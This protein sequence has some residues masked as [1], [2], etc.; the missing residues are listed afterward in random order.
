MPTPESAKA[1]ERLVE[2]RNQLMDAT[3]R[4]N[5]AGR[6]STDRSREVQAEWDV[7]FRAFEAAANDFT[8]SVEQLRDKLDANSGS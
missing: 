2:A 3:K 4:L 7:A 5:E 8:T 1:F 6:S